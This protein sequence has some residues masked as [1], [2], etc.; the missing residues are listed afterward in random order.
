M[1]IEKEKIFNLLKTTVDSYYKISDATWNDFLKICSIRI[2][3]KNE[4]AF[5]SNQKINAISFVY[6]GLFRASTLNIK[7]EEYNKNFF[8][9]SRFF[10]P[11]TS[12]LKDEA[13]ESSVQALEDSIIVDIFY[14]KYRELFY[15]HEDLKLFHILYLEKHWLIQKDDIAYSLVL[16][17]A[18]ERYERFLETY[19][20]ISNRLPLYHVALFLGISPTHLSRIRKELKNRCF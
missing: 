17:D 10:G 14:D 5:V 18:Q 2:L 15:K 11:V 16:E 6:K 4:Y 12:M 1:K 9:E 13:V 3:K 20:N 8:W 19:S 7:G